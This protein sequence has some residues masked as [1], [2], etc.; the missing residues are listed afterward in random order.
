MALQHP[1]KALRRHFLQVREE[2]VLKNSGVEEKI[3]ARLGALLK[4]LDARVVGAYAATRRE[5]DV[6]PCLYG[7]LDEHAT[8]NVAL[9]VIDTD[10]VGKMHYAKWDMKTDLV[11]GAF[12]IVVPKEDVFVVPSV[13]LVP[14]VAFSKTGYRLGYGGGFFDRFLA[15]HDGVESVGVAYDELETD[16]FTPER[17]DKRLDYIVTQSKVLTFD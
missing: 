14:C 7:W 8:G 13:V 15:R 1:R 6:F 5:P 17:F 12:G 16:A 9:P 4:T 3:N 11:N 10:K 2:V